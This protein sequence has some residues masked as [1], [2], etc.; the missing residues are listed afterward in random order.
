MDLRGGIYPG[1]PD[2]CL[3]LGA[4]CPAAAPWVDSP[5]V[6]STRSTKSTK[7][8]ECHLSLRG[9]LGEVGLPPTGAVVGCRWFCSAESP[10]SSSNH[11]R[12][13]ELPVGFSRSRLGVFVS[14]TKTFPYVT[15]AEWG[16]K[17]FHFNFLN[18]YQKLVV[19][20]LSEQSVRS[21]SSLVFPGATTKGAVGELVDKHKSVRTSGNS[22]S[23]KPQGGPV[24]LG[25]DPL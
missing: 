16:K 10:Y 21:A 11:P 8:P 18:A 4:P 17:I 25:K 14:G 15:S 19:R 20:L 22:K 23:R 9:G 12:G 6:Q 2:E 13:L 5:L 3:I 1:K 24:L 7:A